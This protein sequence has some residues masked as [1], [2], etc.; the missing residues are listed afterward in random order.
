[1]SQTEPFT[2]PG[3]IQKRY[4]SRGVD[5]CLGLLLSDESQGIVLTSSSV[6]LRN[7][8]SEYGYEIEYDYKDFDVENQLLQT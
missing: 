7:F 1:M 2:P 8:R 5:Y 4:I 6:V 3:N